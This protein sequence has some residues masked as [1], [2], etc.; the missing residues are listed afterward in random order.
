MKEKISER[1]LGNIR[2]MIRIAAKANMSGMSNEYLLN[3]MQRCVDEFNEWLDI[4]KAEAWDEGATCR[5]QLLE[6]IAQNWLD[7]DGDN[8][9][10][11]S[12][13]TEIEEWAEGYDGKNPYW[14]EKYA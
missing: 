13:L 11:M 6:M 8:F 12:W 7:Y 3:H 1:Q 2:D 14:G 4:V 5:Q 10:L 9:T